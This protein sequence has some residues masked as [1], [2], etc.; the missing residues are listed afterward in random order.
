VDASLSRIA[1]NWDIRERYNT[2]D[3]SPLSEGKRGM[4][5]ATLLEKVPRRLGSFSSGSELRQR[6]ILV[7]RKEILADSNGATM[8]TS[9]LDE[10]LQLRS[11]SARG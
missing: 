7:S 3:I 8:G 11:G 5:L 9:A 10:T 6:S 4:E 2:F 1:K